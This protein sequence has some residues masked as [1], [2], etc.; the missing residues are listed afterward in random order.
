MIQS[1]EHR[2]IIPLLAPQEEYLQK[3][4]TISKIAC[5]TM[6]SAG[7]TFGGVVA[8]EFGVSA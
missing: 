5:A 2:A 3:A 7:A 6:A 4:T 8:S 1:T